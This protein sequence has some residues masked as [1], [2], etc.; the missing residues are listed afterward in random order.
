LKKIIL[1]SKSLD[2]KELFRRMGIPIETFTTNV[3]EGI[4]KKRIKKP[5][6]LA[7]E[8]AKAKALYTKKKQLKKDGDAIIIAADTIVECEGEII[9]KAYNENEAFEILNKL[10]GRTHNL[11]TGIAITEIN[12]SKLIIDSDTTIVEFLELSQKDIWSY[13]KTNEWIGRAG[14]YSIMDKASLFINKI[15][16]SSSNVIGLSMNKVYNI[17]KNEF[18]FNLFQII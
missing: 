18:G 4:Y 2:R 12:N 8:L 3:D 1:A 9:G 6:K 10:S 15:I 14:A 13:I 11:I 5:I 17:L 7:K 16:G